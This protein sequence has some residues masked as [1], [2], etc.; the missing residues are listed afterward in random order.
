MDLVAYGSAVL[1]MVGILL[2]AIYWCRLKDLLNA[3]SED[4]CDDGN[5]LVTSASNAF[6]PGVA[7][8]AC[9]TAVQSSQQIPAVLSSTRSLQFQQ[10]VNGIDINMNVPP[11]STRR[12]RKTASST[13]SRVKSNFRL[14][15]L[16]DTSASP[17]TDEDLLDPGDRL[18]IRNVRTNSSLNNR[19]SSRRSVNKSVTMK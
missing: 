13:S 15:R 1:L 3:P 8:D 6:S 17:I 9:S 14:W 19:S 16:K 12:L 10:P 5:V 2:V 7:S 11:T 4:T 18:N